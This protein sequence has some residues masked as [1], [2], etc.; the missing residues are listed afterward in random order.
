MASHTKLKFRQAG[1]GTV[2]ENKRKDLK[3][4]LERAEKRQK[5]SDDKSE[6]EQKRI[7]GQTDEEAER[8]RVI[9]E[10]ALLDKDDSDDEV[11]EN[12]K[13]K[14]K[15]VE[16][17]QDDEDED[18]SDDDEEDET[19]ELLRELEKIKRERA[20]EK[21]RQ[22]RSVSTCSFELVS[23]YSLQEAEQ[24]SA[25]ATDRD[26]NIAVGNPLLD[27]QAAL[28]GNASPAPSSAGGFSVKRR[29]DDDV[30]F[31][32]QATTEK[33]KKEFVNDLLRTEFHSMF[34]ALP[35]FLFLS[36]MRRTIEKFL[37]RYVK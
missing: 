20:E 30:I 2:S 35:N 29:W 8:R 24:A 19:A 4:E 15:A 21:E 28:N 25:D 10:A 23:T 32:N 27:L 33:P 6:G 18:D 22:V 36:L 31:K 13:G 14:E 3:M 34:L 26:A 11:V 12:G 17:G 5:V 16:N 37:N 7:E 1:Q 9:A